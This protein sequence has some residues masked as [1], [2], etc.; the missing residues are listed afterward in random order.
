MFFKKIPSIS[1]AVLLLLCMFIAAAFKDNY[2]E[3][4]KNLEIFTAVYRELYTGY[5]DQPDADKLMKKGID[6]MLSS[7]DP[8]TSFIPEAETKN[9]RSISSGKYG[10]IGAVI[11]I[12]NQ[13]GV[14]GEIFEGFA[15]DKAG[16]KVGDILKTIN[17]QSTQN[18]KT[19]DI[20]KLLKGEAGTV[21]NLEVKKPGTDKLMALE[22]V[23]E[24]IKIKNIDWYGMLP[25]NV[26]YIKLAG[27]TDGAGQEIKKATEDLLLNKKAARLILD[28]RNNPGGLLHEAVN[29]CNV[30]LPK[31][32]LIVTTKGRTT[33]SEKSYRTLNEVTA[34]NIPLVVLV[35][36]NSAS[37]SEIVSGAL[38][39]L[40]RAVVIG[41]KTF[42]KGLVQNT[43]T[44]PYNTLLKLTTSKYYIPS[45]RCIQ[46]LNYQLRKT[47]GTATSIADSLK[48]TFLTT[49]GRVVYD[50][51]GIQ[52]DVAIAP[53]EQNAF[54]NMIATGD[55]LF[56]FA[57]DY[58]ASH[59]T[60]DT[61]GLA[62]DNSLWQGFESAFLGISTKY[63]NASEKALASLESSVAKENYHSM[64]QSQINS[65]KTELKSLKQKD[66]TLNK[67]QIMPMLLETLAG[68]YYYEAGKVATNVRY[69]PI[70]MQ[71]IT[72]LT[73]PDS[74]QQ[75]L[76]NHQPPATK[77]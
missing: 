12:K 28:L 65:I 60:I 33:A 21:V 9:Y 64:L 53:T 50:G 66:L 51:G 10:G 52:P 8:Y 20:S 24:E 5:V 18:L 40:D 13:E 26:G 45:G 57:T 19:T 56:D 15:A 1:T 4:S 35:N 25:N 47:D 6:E 42:G 23:R 38:Q 54:I 43:R 76:K 69:D 3:L 32:T 7:L 62:V 2:F 49:N 39:D 67:A 68:R 30:Y 16:L 48:K 61:S 37:A 14:V 31:G 46:A 22:I 72:L 55:F 17:G 70:V 58:T 34:Q 11:K 63:E 71:A 73:H 41:Q 27:F 59:N 74:C 75:I 77:K 44:L 29:V 36:G